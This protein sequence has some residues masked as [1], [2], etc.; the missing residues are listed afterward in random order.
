MED[1]GPILEPVPRQPEP[2]PRG[3]GGR[4]D[5]EGHAGAVLHVII[6]ISGFFCGKT[7]WKHCFSVSATPWS[8]RWFWRGARTLSTPARPSWSTGRPGEAAK[9]YGIRQGWKICLL[10]L[11]LVNSV[12]G[13]QQRRRRLRKTGVEFTTVLLLSIFFLFGKICVIPF[14][15]G[16]EFDFYLL[17]S[18]F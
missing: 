16:L 7:W 2:V 17:F 3:S 12:P 13:R 4:R 11:T 9:R 1:G 18:T 5:E 8:T 14:F 6:N 15:F 10:L